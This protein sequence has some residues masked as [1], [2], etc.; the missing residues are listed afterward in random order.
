MLEIPDPL[1]PSIV[2]FPIVLIFLGAVFSLLTIFTRRG[3]LPQFA[4]VILILAAGAAQV[5]V[6]TGG[7]QADEVIRRMPDAKPLVLVH[8]EWGERMRTMA[9]IAAISAVIALASYRLVRFRRVLALITTIL[10]AGAC[11]C[12]YE[13]A[14][15]GGAMVYHHG[16]GVQILPSGSG[17]GAGP[18]SPTPASTPG[19]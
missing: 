9:V 6:N 2:H 15:H 1:H 5:A 18:A 19:G 4:A 16:V 11:Y 3:A 7:D 17:S 12:T 14:K 10:A 8:A 13:A